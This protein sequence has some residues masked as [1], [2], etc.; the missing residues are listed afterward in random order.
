MCNFYDLIK[1]IDSKFSY[2][3]NH[4]E[5][6]K[7]NLMKNALEMYEIISNSQNQIIS[8]FNKNN[9]EFIRAKD[10]KIMKFKVEKFLENRKIEED[11]DSLEK[12][13]SRKFLFI[14]LIKNLSNFIFRGR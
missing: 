7:E 11:I 1:Q 13:I 14:N 3:T 12:K 8:Y 4:M 5:N 10:E 6:E 9:K 2:N